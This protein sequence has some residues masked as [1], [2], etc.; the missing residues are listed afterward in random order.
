MTRDLTERQFNAACARHG[1]KSRHFMGYYEVGNG[2]ETSVLNAGNRR[3]DQLAYL[4]QQSEK[5][6]GEA[7]EE[8]R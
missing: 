7:E 1:F 8:E 2:L 5:A 3:R 4:I 6:A